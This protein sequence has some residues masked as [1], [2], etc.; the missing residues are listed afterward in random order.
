[1]LKETAAL[2]V[3]ITTATM[4]LNVE[5]YELKDVVELEH[6]AKFHRL[7]KGLKIKGSG[8]AKSN[9]FSAVVIPRESAGLLVLTFPFPYRS[10]PPSFGP[11]SLYFKAIPVAAKPRSL[12]K[13]LRGSGTELEPNKRSTYLPRPSISISWSAFAPRFR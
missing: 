5:E 13:R 4:P 12:T 6:P 8:S 3:A 10:V 9:D 2:P 7:R 11:P 1:M